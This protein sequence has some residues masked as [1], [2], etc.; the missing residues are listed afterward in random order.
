MPVRGAPRLQAGVHGRSQDIP[1]RGQQRRVQVALDDDGTGAAG[2]HRV[3][4]P[5]PADG[6]AQVRAVVHADGAPAVAPRS[7][8]PHVRQDPGRTCA[9]VDQRDAGAGGGRDR[10]AGDAQ[11][12][13]GVG[14]HPLAVV[15]RGQGPG[16]GVEELGGA[17]PRAHLGGDEGAGGPGAPGHEGVPGGGVGAH[18]GARGQVVPAR[19]ALDEVG[20]QGER[21]AAEADERGPRRPPARLGQAGAGAL[22]QTGAAARRGGGPQLD[23]GGAH[24]GLDGARARLPGGALPV[25][26]GGQAGDVVGRAHRVADDGAHARLDPHVQAR[27]AQRHHNVGEEDGGVHPVAPHGLERDLGREPGGQAGLEHAQAGPPPQLPVLRQAPP[28]LAHE[29][30]GGARR[31]GARER[32]EQGWRG[33]GAASARIW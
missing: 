24:P 2:P 5:Q 16:P 30:H 3:A 23:D 32:R 9:E 22:G 12:Q 26:A 33:G 17:R 10:L 27:H 8:G 13:G 6:P 7:R 28:R 21:R 18:E 20:R 29:P 15:R 25:A 14:G 31:A 1:G 11:G 19:T 4:G